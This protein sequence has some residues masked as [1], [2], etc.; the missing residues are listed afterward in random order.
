MY[1][2]K[3][4]IILISVFSIFGC[5][6]KTTYSGK[7]ITQEDL[8]NVNITNKKELIQTFGQPSYIDNIFNKYFYYTEKNKNKNF[9]SNKVAYSYLFV[10]EIDKNDKIIGTESINLLNNDNQIFR[11]NETLN[12]IIE[13]GLIE[14]IFGG[15][16]PS[17]LPN[18][19]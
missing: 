14:K 3:P 8:S 5:T 7:I 9:Y 17:Q 19:P 2:I 11:K 12:N 15:V 4:L 6:E 10:F 18:S 13:R 16:G 1:F